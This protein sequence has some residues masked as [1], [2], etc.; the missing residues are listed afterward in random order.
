MDNVPHAKNNLL[1]L[2]IQ[3]DTLPT[4]SSISETTYCSLALY[5]YPYNPPPQLGYCP[6]C[7]TKQPPV[8]FGKTW[9]FIYCHQFLCNKW[10]FY[11]T[12]HMFEYYRNPHWGGFLQ[13]GPHYSSIS[14]ISYNISMKYH[15][16]TK[17]HPEVFLMVMVCCYNLPVTKF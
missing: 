6:I 11:N 14:G 3:L 10:L 5:F 17:Y 4:V 1:W 2:M 12:M 7:K 9:Y 8:V 13:Q 16:T 15:Q